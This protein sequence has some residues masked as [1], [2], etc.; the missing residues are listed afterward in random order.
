M[1][2][3]YMNS[4]SPPKPN[5]P[6]APKPSKFF[7]LTKLHWTL[8]SLAYQI[9]QSPIASTKMNWSTLNCF[10]STK[11]PS[12]WYGYGEIRIW[13]NVPL[14]DMSMERLKVEE[15]GES[16][17]EDCEWVNL[18]FLECFSLKILSKSSLHFVGIRVFIV[19][20]MRNVKG[21]FS[22]NRAFWQLD[23]ATGTSCEFE[24]WANFLARLEV[25]SYS[26]PAVVTLQLSL[27]ASHVCHSSD[28]PIARSSCEALLECTHLKL[29]SHSL[30][31]YPYIIPT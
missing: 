27:H 24:S 7:A 20:Y 4:R 29:S 15:F 2:L 5:L 13:L 16:K 22:S 9:S 21:Q 1:K 23:L 19:G 6:S 28:F 25:L 30:T 3:G 11:I 8:S 18:V 31:H 26:V 10:P 12:H 14:K 17:D